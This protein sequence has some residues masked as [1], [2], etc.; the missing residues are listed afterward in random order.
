MKSRSIVDMFGP[1]PDSIKAANPQYFSLFSK[2][3]GL[4]NVL[5]YVE[6]QMLSDGFDR[7][8]VVSVIGRSVLSCMNSK[9][10]LLG[11]LIGQNAF[12]PQVGEGSTL[13]EDNFAQIDGYYDTANQIVF[14]HLTSTFDSWSLTNLYDDIQKQFLEKGFL[15]QWPDLMNDLLKSLILLFHISHVVVVSNQTPRFDIS[16]IN[17]FRIIDS[18]RVKLQPFV[19]EM[20]QSVGGLPTFWIKSGRFCVPQLLFTFEA[21]EGFEYINNDNYQLYVQQLEDQITRVLRKSRLLSAMSANSLF[22]ISSS[23][24]FVF[25]STQNP[26]IS[27]Y[28]AF[29][30]ERIFNRCTNEATEGRS[31]YAD[32]YY[33]LNKCN[34][35]FL[36]F[37]LPHINSTLS[38]NSD[39][40]SSTKPTPPSNDLVNTYSFFKVLISFKELIFSQTYASISA[41]KSRNL[42]KIFDSLYSTLDT[43]NRFSEGRCSKMVHNA[44]SYYQEN[45]PSHYTRETHERKLML[46]LQY[47]TMNSRGPAIYK[48]IQAVQAECDKFWNSGRKMCEELSLTGNYCMNKVHRLPHEEFAPNADGSFQSLPIML[49]SSMTKLVSACN[50]GRRSGNRIDPFTLKEANYDFYLKMKFKCHTCRHVSQYKF[51]VYDNFD[52][53]TLSSSQN[54]TNKSENRDSPTTTRALGVLPDDEARPGGDCEEVDASEVPSPENLSN[55]DDLLDSPPEN[56]EEGDEENYVITCSTKSDHHPQRKS[57]QGDSAVTGGDEGSEKDALSGNDKSEALSKPELFLTQSS[58][59]EEYAEKHFSSGEEFV[60]DLELNNTSPETGKVTRANVDVSSLPPM[61]HTLCPPNTPARFSSWSLVCLGSSSIYSHNLGITDQQGFIHGSHYLLPWNV[62]VILEHGRHMPPLWE[63][64]KKP[65]GVKHMKA[66]KSGTQ[67]TVKIFIGVEYECL[68]GHRFIS[69]G[70]DQVLKAN[71]NIFSETA[72]A[73]TTNDMPVYMHCICSRPGKSPTLAQLMR[74]HIVTPKAPI[75]VTLNPFVQMTPNAS[76]LFFPGNTEPIKLSQSSY[77]V[78]RLPMFY[79]ADNGP[80]PWPKE[81][82]SYCRLLKGCYSIADQVTKV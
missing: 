18:I 1:V 37:L 32:K 33:S 73:S 4:Q 66:L 69:C 28:N 6:E 7:V 2:D 3:S 22:S 17:L 47:F 34:Q 9:A 21:Y 26:I 75:H 61:I 10:S 44:V 41:E 53:E 49:H 24:P 67:F 30:F 55:N 72:S 12:L 15:N 25:I 23:S 40:N 52:V 78:L 56:A 68:R 35:L 5:K 8:G 19:S 76:P 48:Y 31:K 60:S 62:T 13:F 57:E 39:E 11:S 27:D 64:G 59:N 58:D 45:L 65:P 82:L 80:Y 79:E 36:S 51:P 71:S 63:R 46:T 54:M 43:D 16:C 50:C 70:P 14:L 77:W 38:K 81:P 42:M 74:I 20:L 29:F